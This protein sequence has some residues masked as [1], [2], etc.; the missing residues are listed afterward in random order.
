MLREIG[1]IENVPEFIKGVKAGSGRLMGFGH[2]VYK[3]Y[4]PRAKII[5][6]LADEVFEVT[7]KNP[8]LDIALE[9]ERIALRT[10][11]SS[12]RKLY[13]NVDFYSGLIYQAMGFPIAMLHRAVRHPAHRPYWLAPQW[14]EMLG[15][16]EQKIVAPAPVYTGADVRDYVTTSIRRCR[17]RVSGTCRATRASVAAF[18]AVACHSG[19]MGFRLALTS[20]LALAMNA[21]RDHG[22]VEA[23]V[24]KFEAARRR[25][26]TGRWL[27]P[28]SVLALAAVYSPDPSKPLGLA[29]PFD[30]DTGELDDAVFARWLAW[31]PANLIDDPQHQDAAAGARPRLRRRR[32]ARRVPP[33][34]GRAD[35]PRKATRHGIRHVYEEF[36]DG[37]R[38]TGYRLDTSLP[39]LYAA[40][41]GGV[42]AGG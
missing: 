17:C 31:D 10:S 40:L 11:T 2:R 30:L 4:D 24:E 12:Q 21:I 5:K 39:L 34:L 32:Q 7:G 36:D 14:E 13:P 1:S 16:K 23:L 9:L 26:R 3:N 28:I 27:A 38:N 22:G 41:T 25:R 20:E 19:D 42:A 29:L 15:D 6:K 33:A 35:L 18:R 8:L 37:H